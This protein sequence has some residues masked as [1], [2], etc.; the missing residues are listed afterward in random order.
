MKQSFVVALLALASCRSYDLSSRLTSQRG[1]IPADQYARY[2]REQAQEIAIAREFGHASRGTS[3]EDLMS[4]A[5]SASSYARALP[6]VAEVKADPLGL[7]L[8]IRFKSGW[9]TM[10]TPIKNGK[11]GAETTGLPGGAGART[12]R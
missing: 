5:D 1:L 9:R 6:D 2:G 8:T 11:R 12:T 3:P 4:Q 7:L 10:T